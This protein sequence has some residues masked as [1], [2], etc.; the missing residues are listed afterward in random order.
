MKNQ[1]NKFDSVKLYQKNLQKCETT[2][3]S[4]KEG[5]RKNLKTQEAFIHQEGV[6]YKSGNFHIGS[7]NIKDWELWWDVSNIQNNQPMKVTHKLSYSK[8]ESECLRIS[9]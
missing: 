4:R 9:K 8:V 7:N 2:K 3:T 6:I 1:S 5:K